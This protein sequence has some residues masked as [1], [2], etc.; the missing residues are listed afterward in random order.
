LTGSEGP[1]TLDTNIAVY[2]LSLDAKA[3]RA[4]TLLRNSDFL[5][6][7]VLNEYANVG[8]R[9]RRDPW[10]VIG[11]DLAALRD[12]APRILPIDDDASR[13]AARISERYRLS[14]Y[15]ALMLAVA[16]AGGARTI[17]SEDMQHSLVI[18]DTLRIVDPFR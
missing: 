5:S 9:K 10:D 6:V 13:A 15:D 8:L 2:A 3:D 4:A 12:A 1:A 16:L 18:D 7:Q 11:A 14:F 17:Y